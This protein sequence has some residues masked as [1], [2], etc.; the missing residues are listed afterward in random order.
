MCF[1]VMKPAILVGNF[2]FFALKVGLMEDEDHGLVLSTKDNAQ[3][4]K[5]CYYLPAW[6]E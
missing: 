4:L 5:L 1:R 3:F 6:E 2:I